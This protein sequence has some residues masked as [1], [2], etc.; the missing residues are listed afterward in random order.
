[1][2]TNLNVQYSLRSS[3][4]AFSC[5]SLCCVCTQRLPDGLAKDIF[6]LFN[7]NQNIPADVHFTYIHSVLRLSQKLFQLTALFPLF[8]FFLRSFSKTLM[9]AF[10]VWSLHYVA[11][12]Y[13]PYL[14]GLENSLFPHLN[15]TIPVKFPS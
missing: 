11:S 14:K 3:L 13:L 6:S 4:N 5:A 1:M 2:P 10:Q 9:L 12:L 8:F 15:R 7:E